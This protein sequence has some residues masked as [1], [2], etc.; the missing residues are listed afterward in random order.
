MASFQTIA[1]FIGGKFHLGLP[2]DKP[3]HDWPVWTLVALGISSEGFWSL[4]QND[5]GE[6]RQASLDRYKLT[7]IK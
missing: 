4:L 7:R 6:T 5:E 2:L 1:D 3:Y